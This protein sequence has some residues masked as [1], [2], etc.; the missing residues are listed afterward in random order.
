MATKVK[1]AQLKQR[2]AEVLASPHHQISLTDPDARSMA[3]SHDIGMVGYN[4]QSA[5]DTEHHLIVQPRGDELSLGQ[6]ASLNSGGKSK[7]RYGSKAA[8]LIWD[9]SIQCLAL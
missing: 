2:E 1:L 9:V 6:S 5:V 3:T 7:G 4:V 8:R